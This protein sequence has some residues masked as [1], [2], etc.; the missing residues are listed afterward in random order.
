MFARIAEFAAHTE[1]PSV[2][3]SVSAALDS[4]SKGEKVTY[5]Y[6]WINRRRSESLDWLSHNLTIDKI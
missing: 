1:G 5:D 4:L 3:D 2:V 6:E